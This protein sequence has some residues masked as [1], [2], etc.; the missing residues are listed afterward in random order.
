MSKNSNSNINNYINNI[1][2]YTYIKYI[3]KLII[4]FAS[5]MFLL[6]SIIDFMD[7]KPDNTEKIITALLGL[8]LVLIMNQAVE[9]L[10][11][12]ISNYKS[13]EGVGKI[14]DAHRAESEIVFESVMELRRAIEKSFNVQKIESMD[15]AME[16]VVSRIERAVKIRNTYLGTYVDYT[17]DR[18]INSYNSHLSKEGRS[19]HDIVSARELFSNR[20]D[21]INPKGYTIGQHKITVLS[22]SLPIINFIIIEYP[23]FETEVFWGW[24]ESESSGGFSSTTIFRSAQVELV[25]MFENLFTALCLSNVQATIHTDFQR[26]GDERFH[27]D[28]NRKVVDREGFWFTHSYNISRN[29][30]KISL[31]PASYA[32]FTIKYRDGAAQIDGFLKEALRVDTSVFNVIDH[33]RQGRTDSSDRRIVIE[34][35]FEED[36]NVKVGYVLYNFDR[37]DGYDIVYGFYTNPHNGRYQEIY[38]IKLSRELPRYVTKE[39]LDKSISLQS[40]LVNSMYKSRYLKS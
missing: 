21:R 23:N 24:V 28:C 11:T 29:A 3:V 35:P 14:I 38:G 10:E 13:G 16:A 32:C 9:A 5:F 12:I 36:G 2:R 7:R 6:Q 17:D 22:T 27:T 39:F 30:S 8:V 31:K 18:I 37:Q 34:F 4:Y 19:W 20:Y 1:E 26:K 33:D 25:G 15:D 40:E